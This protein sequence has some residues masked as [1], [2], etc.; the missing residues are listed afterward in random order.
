MSAFFLN[1]WYASFPSKIISLTERC[2][3]T[4]YSKNSQIYSSD[5]HPFKVNWP[6]IQCPNN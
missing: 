2:S 3:I 6:I 4:S 1:Q 5:P